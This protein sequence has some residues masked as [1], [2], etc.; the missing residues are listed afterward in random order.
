MADFPWIAPSFP[1]SQCRFFNVCVLIKSFISALVGDAHT[2]TIKYILLVWVA[3]S[4]A[5]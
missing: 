1:D 5:D 4:G 2:N 3:F